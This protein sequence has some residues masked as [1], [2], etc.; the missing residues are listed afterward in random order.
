[1]NLFAPPSQAAPTVG[2]PDG[3][4]TCATHHTAHHEAMADQPRDEAYIDLNLVAW[5][6]HMLDDH[7]TKDRL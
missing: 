1:M 4:D 3:C 5:L 7:Q 6:G 2:L